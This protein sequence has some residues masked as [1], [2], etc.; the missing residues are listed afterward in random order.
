MLIKIAQDRKGLGK[1]SASLASEAL[2]R[3]LEKQERARI[4]VATGSSQFEVLDALTKE[5][6]IDWARVDGF[7]LDEYLGLRSDHPA[8]FCGYLTK[9]FVE[10]VPIG[11]FHYLDGI[12][13]P[14]ETIA[15]ASKAWN[16]APIDVALIGIGENGHLAFNDPPADFATRAIYHVVDLDLACR[17][18]QVG[19]GWFATIAECP[20]RAIS[21]TIH[22]IL[23]SKKIICSVPD[24][25]KSEAVRQ[26]VEGPV[27]PEVPG[28]ILQTHHDVTLVLDVASASQMHPATIA[29]ARHETEGHSAVS[30]ELRSNSNPT[31]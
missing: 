20:S 14:L 7:H 23:A 6:G 25:R 1:I 9:R 19:E 12:R 28:S 13:D 15:E 30:N 24:S 17:Q 8:S 4:V 22:G 26:S 3:T 29:S 16:Q 10:L 27:V 31:L 11:S 21:M 2:R 5:S 18:Q